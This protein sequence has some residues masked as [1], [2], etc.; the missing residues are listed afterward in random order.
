MAQ[1]VDPQTMD[2]KGDLFPVRRTVSRG[3]VTASNLYSVSGN[4]I[5]IYQTGGGG[6]GNSTSGSTTPAKNWG[7]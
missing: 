6:P 2:A 4:G 3:P 1:P 7:P 5:L